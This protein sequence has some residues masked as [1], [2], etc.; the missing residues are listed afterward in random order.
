MILQIMA[1]FASIKVDKRFTA[2]GLRALTGL[3]RSD[4][5]VPQR[6]GAQKSPNYC[7]II[8]NVESPHIIFLKNCSFCK[9]EE[10][11]RES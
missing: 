7:C 6:S 4:S 11:D 2:D 5:V 8:F 9:I 3:V 10:D 1:I